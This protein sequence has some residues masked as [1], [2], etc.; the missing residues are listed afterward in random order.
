[1]IL[2]L[3]PKLLRLDDQES[4]RPTLYA[5]E[6]CKKLLTCKGSFFGSVTMKSMLLQFL[7]QY[8]MIYD[9]RDRQSLLC[10]YHDE[11]CF[12]LTIPSKLKNPDPRS[13]C[14]YFKE[15]SNMRKLKDPYPW[16][17]LMKH[18][19]QD[20]VDTLSVLPKTQ[21]D[22]SSFVVDMWFQTELMV[23]FS[24]NGVFKEVEGKSHGSVHAF[25]RTFIAMPTSNFSLCIV[26]DKLFVWD[27]SPQG[28]QRNFS[29]PKFK[30]SS[31]SI[32]NL[33][34]EQQDMVR[35]FS[36]QSGM[37]L[38]WCQQFLQNNH[39]DYKRAAQVLALSKAKG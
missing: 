38:E 30:P 20:I 10:A 6:A 26:N 18:T 35:A 32:P 24:V 12:S 1:S 21:H 2:E 16:R 7:K 37:N 15:S 27:S 25:T 11:A 28:I 17:Q 9:S 22:L 29:I 19:K 13:L 4:P 33:S 3:F 31:S 14:E 23:C 39:W 36:A 5:T 34:Q 8:Y